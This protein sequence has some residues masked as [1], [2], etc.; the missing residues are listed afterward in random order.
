MKLTY[1]SGEVHTCL[2]FSKYIMNISSKINCGN[3]TRSLLI[4][5][6]ND[7]VIELNSVNDT[8]AYQTYLFDELIIG[9]WKLFL[10][11]KTLVEE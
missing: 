9:I 1:E 10:T 4:K 5:F 3:N 8:N 6:S 7:E 2:Y 11:S